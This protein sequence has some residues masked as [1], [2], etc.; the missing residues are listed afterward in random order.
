M[1]LSYTEARDLV[2]LRYK[3][4]RFNNSSKLEGRFV[5]DKL[6][7]NHNRLSENIL[8]MDN[9]RWIFLLR[10]PEDT[11]KSI[12][13]MG[14]KM[15]YEDWYR[16]HNKILLYY[17]ER[18]QMMEHIAKKTFGKSIFI[19]SEQ[20]ITNIDAVLDSITNWLGLNKRLDS[21]YNIFSD[22]GLPWYGDPS[23][24]I[25]SGY[26]VKNKPAYNDIHIPSEILKKAD[27]DYQNCHSVISR[28]SNKAI[29][30]SEP[31]AF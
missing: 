15:A 1:H 29:K 24:V 18:L 22:T 7:S 13:N 2:R 14:N 8:S 25:K 6:L 10:S 5:L 11:F 4:S 23:G 20:L 21:E 9:I 27:S 26:I 31:V 12:V 17:Q 28:Y 19:E 3:V 30:L 16:D